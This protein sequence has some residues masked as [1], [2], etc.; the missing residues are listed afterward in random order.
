MSMH[1]S[2]LKL[3]FW[4]QI[5]YESSCLGLTT[6]P[7]YD[8]I[9]DIMVFLRVFLF[10]IKHLSALKFWTWNWG[11]YMCPLDS[12]SEIRIFYESSCSYLSTSPHSH[13]GSA[14][15]VFL[16]VILVVPK[17]LSTLWFWN[18]GVYLERENCFSDSPT[19]AST[20]KRS[21]APTQAQS[22]DAVPPPSTPCV[23]RVP[24]TNAPKAVGSPP[25]TLRPEKRMRESEGEK[26]SLGE[27]VRMLNEAAA[28]R[29]HQQLGAQQNLFLEN[30]KEQ[31]EVFACVCTTIE[32]R[33]SYFN[34][35]NIV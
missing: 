7:P 20:S 2:T 19:R 5:F 1:V 6:F 31:K 29:L 27:C 35:V 15:G 23:P 10:A 21:R 13:S 28:K 25:F 34:I 4:N 3:W 18:W 22:T 24:G 33:R 11:F 16:W 17:H 30:L 14:I 8:S 9:S 32:S 26:E 12:G